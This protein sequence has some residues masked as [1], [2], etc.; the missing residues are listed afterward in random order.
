M[1][2]TIVALTLV[3]AILCSEHPAAALDELRLGITAHNVQLWGGE[4]QSNESG[5]NI[6]LQ[7]LWAPPGPIRFLGSPRPYAMIS[8]NTQGDTSYASGGLEWRWRFAHRWSLDPSFGLAVHDGAVNEKYPVG[9]PEELIY[10]E[11]H[12]LLGS[13]VLFH[14]TLAVQRELTKRGGLA[15]TY[16]HLSNGGTIFGHKHNQSLNEIGL[17]YTIRLR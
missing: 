14:E 12:Q 6:E 1:T 3:S 5:P 16:E 10:Q 11:R 15:V 4:N 7:A 13:R 9:S 17:R 2:R 8:A